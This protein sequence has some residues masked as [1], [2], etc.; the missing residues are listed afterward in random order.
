MINSGRNSRS[1]RAAAC[2]AALSVLLSGC[3]LFRREERIPPIEKL[4]RE[5]FA[6]LKAHAVAGALLQ[7][8][9]DEIAARAMV[10]LKLPDMARIE[11][12]GPFNG[13]AVVIAVRGKDCSYGLNGAI[14][15]CGGRALFDAAP[16]SSVPFL[17]GSVDEA[18]FKDGVRVRV[19]N[20]TIVLN[21]EDRALIVELS[22]YRDVRG[23]SIP[24]SVKTFAKGKTFHVKYSSVELNPGELSGDTG[25]FFTLQPR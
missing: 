21:Y 16:G 17:M 5:N 2:L 20:G 7:G 15:P 19:E 12:M 18:S 22:D 23:L 11:V 1:S 14:M 4:E 25:D 6:S 8:R 9:D 10:Y 3:A 24:F 13:L